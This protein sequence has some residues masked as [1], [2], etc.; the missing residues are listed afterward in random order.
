MLLYINFIVYKQ[1]VWYYLERR[2]KQERNYYPFIYKL[3]NQNFRSTL[4][5]LTMKTNII[6]TFNFI[7]LSIGLFKYLLLDEFSILPELLRKKKTCLRYIH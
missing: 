4:T 5:K 7:P 1:V 6:E 2:L 3:T